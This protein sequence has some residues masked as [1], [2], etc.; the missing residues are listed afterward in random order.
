MSFLA[1]D[2][3]N[4]RLK[5]AIYDQ[6][7]PGAALLQHGAVFLETIDELAEGPWRALPAPHV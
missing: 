3:G 5:W 7:R 1:L 4:T 6:P 2:I